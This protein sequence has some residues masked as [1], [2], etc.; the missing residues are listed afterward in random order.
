M[1]N[2]SSTDGNQLPGKSHPRHLQAA[3]RMPR[4]RWSRD[5]PSGRTSTALGLGR[6]EKKTPAGPRH[7]RGRWALLLAIH[8]AGLAVQAYPIPAASRTIAVKAKC[9]GRSRRIKHPALVRLLGAVGATERN[10]HGV[11]RDLGGQDIPTRDGGGGWRSARRVQHR[12]NGGGNGDDGGEA[13]KARHRLSSLFGVMDVGFLTVEPR[14][15]A[16]SA[17][18]ATGAVRVRQGHSVSERTERSGSLRNPICT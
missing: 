11:G 3:P 1:L 14:Q 10:G 2:L 16:I 5:S 6:A 4:R 18:K 15:G 9:S 8:L 7:A 12:K 17:L 13:R